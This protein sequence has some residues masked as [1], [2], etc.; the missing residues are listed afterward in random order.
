M[1]L[2]RA[3]EPA[4]VST[5]TLQASVSSKPRVTRLGIKKRLTQREAAILRK[6]AALKTSV[7]HAQLGD[8]DR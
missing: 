3:S 4:I 8:L 1:Q 6:L 7:Q 5:S 2:S